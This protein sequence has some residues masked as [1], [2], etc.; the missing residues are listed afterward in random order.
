MKQNKFREAVRLQWVH[1]S[2]LGEEW[3][4][5]INF[6]WRKYLKSY[7]VIEQI[8]AF[9]QWHFEAINSTVRVIRDCRKNRWN[10]VR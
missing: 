10:F 6:F 5:Q 7:F 4:F 3:K 2:A 9:F 8:V 1:E